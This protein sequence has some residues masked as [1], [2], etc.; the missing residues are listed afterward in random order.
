[1][2][3]V[4]EISMAILSG[5][6]DRDGKGIDRLNSHPGCSGFSVFTKTKQK[7]IMFLYL[8]IFF[9]RLIMR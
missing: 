4:V 2:N 5:M 7:K 8:Q 3:K 9:S 6:V 1:M